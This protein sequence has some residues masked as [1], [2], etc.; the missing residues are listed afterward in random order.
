[1]QEKMRQSK[2]REKSS[3]DELYWKI[4]H[5][6]YRLLSTIGGN[7]EMDQLYTTSQMSNNE[8]EIFS[9]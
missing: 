8:N 7:R 9:H 1:M 2:N 3:N 5:I 6:K 4:G